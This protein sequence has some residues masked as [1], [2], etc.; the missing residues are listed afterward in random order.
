V[1]NLAQHIQDRLLAWFGP[2]TQPSRA[3]RQSALGCPRI[4]EA[5]DELAHAR[6]LHG[7]GAGPRGSRDLRPLA[8]TGRQMQVVFRMQGC[9]FEESDGGVR[10]GEVE[11][12]QSDRRFVSRLAPPCG[13][14][15]DRVPAQRDPGPFGP[16]LT[17][18]AGHGVAVAEQGPAD[19]AGIGQGVEQVRLAR[20]QRADDE[21]RHG[22]PSG[23]SGALPSEMGRPAVGAGARR[24]RHAHRSRLL[25]ILTGV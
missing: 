7:L 21:I 12:V 18:V 10:V 16:V 5:F 8:P 19:Q 1:R 4:A 25:P 11:P 2:E 24:R 13:A 15:D 9:C 17:A 23:E 22:S 3:S 14:G 6:R 20:D